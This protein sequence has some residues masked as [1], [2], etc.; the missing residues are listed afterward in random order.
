MK[1]A[2]VIDGNNNVQSAITQELDETKQTLLDLETQAKQMS[3]VIQQQ[4]EKIASLEHNAMLKENQMQKLRTDNQNMFIDLK[5]LAQSEERTQR[6]LIELRKQRNELEERN[7]Q[8]VEQIQRMQAQI[9][10]CYGEN[11]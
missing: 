5:S 9:R 6:E 8:L 1:L 7:E 4:N 10:S 3:L 11:E 2:S